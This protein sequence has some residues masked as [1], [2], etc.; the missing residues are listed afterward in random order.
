MLLDI[1]GN[2]FAKLEKLSA[3]FGS[4]AANTNMSS[5]NG[6][7]LDLRECMSTHVATRKPLDEFFGAAADLLVLHLANAK[8]QPAPVLTLVG[9][10]DA[11]RFK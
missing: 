6:F 3:H 10:T 8:K 5:E 11:P 9:G 1:A 2:C 4:A 7:T